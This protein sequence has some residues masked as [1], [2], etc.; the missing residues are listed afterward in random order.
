M[1]LKKQRI[2]IVDDNNDI[3][4]IL[5]EF[6]L[7]QGFEVECADNGLEALSLFSANHFDA[8]LTDFQMPLMNGLILA[9][10]IRIKEPQTLIIMMTSDIWMNAQEYDF[11]DYIVEK[12]FRLKEIYCILQGAIES[13]VPVYL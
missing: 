6:L 1:R 4:D 13:K 5:S 2:L 10:E 8:V 11:I 9:H 7:M 12:P 3:L